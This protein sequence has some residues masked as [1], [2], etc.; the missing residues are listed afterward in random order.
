MLGRGR[1]CPLS[2]KTGPCRGEPFLEEVGEGLELDWG[3][4]KEVRSGVAKAVP[5][6]TMGRTETLYSRPGRK[7]PIVADRTRGPTRIV[8][9]GSPL[10]VVLICAA[11]MRSSMLLHSK[12]DSSLRSLECSGQV[13]GYSM[14]SPALRHSPDPAPS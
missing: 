7:S 2:Q 4:V 13:P 9:G 3:L 14:R 6:V 10:E 8:R 12:V 1:D 11:S 5:L